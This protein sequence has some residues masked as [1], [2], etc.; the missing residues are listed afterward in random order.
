ML[1]AGGRLSSATDPD[2][3]LREA[4]RRVIRF[5]ACSSLVQR[6]VHCAFFLFFFFVLLWD[7]GMWRNWGGR[8]ATRDPVR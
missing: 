5:L 1:C 6:L 4:G 8:R 3:I 2:Y 7:T